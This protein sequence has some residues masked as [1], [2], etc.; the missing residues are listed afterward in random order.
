MENILKWTEYMQKKY[1][2]RKKVSG[3]EIKKWV[4]VSTI[5][6]EKQVYQRI[7]LFVE[8]KN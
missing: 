6:N 7:T 1:F 5:R 4:T 3:R 8:S 2:G